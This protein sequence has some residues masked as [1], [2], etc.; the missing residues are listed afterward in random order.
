MSRFIQE[1]YALAGGVD[2]GWHSQERHWKTGQVI[3]HST[4]HHPVLI[5]GL[6]L[7]LASCPL[8]VNL[9]EHEHIRPVCKEFSRGSFLEWIC[10]FH[11]SCSGW[12]QGLEMSALYVD[13][14]GKKIQS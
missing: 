7:V 1:V 9:G 12:L 3:Q 11:W 4:P 5:I 10:D 8:S 2:C 6:L 14:W 13:S